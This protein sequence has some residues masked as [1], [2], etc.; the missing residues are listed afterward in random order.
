MSKKT[1]VNRNPDDLQKWDIQRIRSHIG[2]VYNL[3][4]IL[5]VAIRGNGKTYG[6]LFL[7]SLVRPPGWCIQWI[8]FSNSFPLNSSSKDIL[9]VKTSLKLWVW[10]YHEL[11]LTWRFQTN[12]ASDGP[13]FCNTRWYIFTVPQI[14]VISMFVK[15]GHWTTTLKGTC[16]NYWQGSQ[17][18]PCFSFI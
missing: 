15:T 12:W 3:K 7:K 5:R 10:W 17:K 2:E 14:A 16:Q 8:I 1:Q 6:N 9:S 18:E 4:D 13:N 11:G